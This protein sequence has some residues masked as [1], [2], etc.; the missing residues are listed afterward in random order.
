[1]LNSMRDETSA[2]NGGREGAT[3]VTMAFAQ[4]IA[5]SWDKTSYPVR[6]SPFRP[7]FRFEDKPFR[8]YLLLL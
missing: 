4:K 2:R 7:Q 6:V 1:M 8:F 5:Y 3:P